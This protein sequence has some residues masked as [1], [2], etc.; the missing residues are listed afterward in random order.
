M[1][2]EECLQTYDVKEIP[3]NKETAKAFLKLCNERFEV[4]K[5]IDKEKYP[6]LLSEAYY[7]GDRRE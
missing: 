5:G 7:E 4:A 3:K 6:A 1:R 2:W